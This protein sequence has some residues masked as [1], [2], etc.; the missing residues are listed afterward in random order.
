MA[1]PPLLQRVR[2][3]KVLIIGL[4]GATY[5]ILDRLMADGV[6]PFLRDFIAQGVRA[7][8]RTIIPA[9]TPP[10][11]TSLRT[12]V[13]PGKHGI[14]D[15]FRKAAPDSHHIEMLTGKDIAAPTLAQYANQHDLTAAVLNFPVTF[16][17]PPIQGYLIPGWMPWKQ[18]RFA[19]QPADFYGRLKEL[20]GFNPRELA[21]DMKQE[22][23]AIE[24]TAE[25][26]YKAWIDVHI[27]K[28][29]QWLQIVRLLR[30]SDPP[31]Y[32]AIM[33]DGTDKIQHL[34]WRFLDPACYSLQPDDFELEMRDYVLRY[35]RALDEVIQG[36]AALAFQDAA[37]FIVSDHGFG[38]QAFTFF[39]N[40]WLEQQGLLAWA[41]DAPAVSDQA[42]LGIG[43]LARHTYLLDWEK[44]LAYA[45]T[46]SANGIHIVRQSAEHPHGV[47]AEMYLPFRDHLVAQ[48]QQVVDPIHGQPLV[49]EIWTREEIFA[50]PYMELAPDLTLVMRDG[51]LISILAAETAVAPRSVISGTHAPLGI[52]A[53]QGS[54]LQAGLTSP[55]LSILDIAPLAL[56]GM[57][58]PIP[59]QLDGRL[60]T[61]LF[62]PHALTA[63]PPLVA[64]DTPI[65][66]Q[67]AVNAEETLDEESE[68]AILEQL[69]KL[70]YV[71]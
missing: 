22:E 13:R 42:I 71:E 52:F 21:M 46:P 12:G 56:Y 14:F 62:D 4:D 2:M 5:T 28:D 47:S 58:L 20:P 34:M 31:D 10:A 59:A 32:T 19:C 24:G 6:M 25:E 35:Y 30:E 69:A 1:T 26:E 39:V 51:G 8:L 27:R 49:A 53:A 37:I 16:P 60:P 23:K 61:E 45:P 3:K 64:E 15:F 17:S 68:L 11:W 55:E 43:Q 70:G 66:S 54:G 44:T 65:P 50:G 63:R 18:L 36:I 48:L 9:L 41:K 29:R 67:P 7:P 57:G 38:Q 40:T 33:F